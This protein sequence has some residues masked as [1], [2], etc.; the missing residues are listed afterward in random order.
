MGDGAGDGRQE[1]WNDGRG[2]RGWGR[3][4]PSGGGGSCSFEHA[5]NGGLELQRIAYTVEGI[6]KD[7][8]GYR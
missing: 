4:A 5:K 1:S 2:A 7:Y 8:C 6:V 3:G